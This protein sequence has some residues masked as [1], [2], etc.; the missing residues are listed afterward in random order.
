[1]P[2]DRVSDGIAAWRFVTTFAARCLLSGV[3]AGELTD[4]QQIVIEVA[5]LRPSF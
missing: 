1:M 3:F 4:S 5:S 2:A